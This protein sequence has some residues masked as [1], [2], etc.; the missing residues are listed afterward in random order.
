MK[1]NKDLKTFKYN[2][3]KLIS[4]HYLQLYLNKYLKTIWIFRKVIKHL[5]AQKYSKNNID[6]IILLDKEVNTF[7]VTTVN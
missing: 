6:I 7:Y 4:M 5:C 3:K 2:Y 1:L